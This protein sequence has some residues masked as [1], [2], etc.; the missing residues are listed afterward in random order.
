MKAVE[1]TPTWLPEVEA[2][3]QPSPYADLMR[4]FAS[5]NDR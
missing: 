4:S 5:Q 2:N 1:Q 3:P